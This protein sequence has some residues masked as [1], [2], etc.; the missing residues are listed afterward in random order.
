MPSLT[1]KPPT[2]PMA[3][4]LE[5]TSG[6]HGGR[7][8]DFPQAEGKTHEWFWGPYDYERVDVI[9][10]SMEKNGWDGPP[11]CIVDGTLRNGHHR[12]IAAYMV[13]MEDIPWTDDWDESSSGGSWG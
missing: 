4:V 5:L 1:L 8:G 13:G 2:M 10:A 6:D 9:A 3:Q 11:V 12:T 7:M